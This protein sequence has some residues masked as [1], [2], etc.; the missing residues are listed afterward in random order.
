[1][2]DI[3]ILEQNLNYTFRD[4]SL[5]RNALVHPSYLNE[6]NMERIY[7]NQRL[8]FFG[9]SVLSLA[10][11]EY[12]FT[13]LKNF[14]EGRLTELRAKVVCEESLAKMAQRLDVGS[15]LALGKGEIKSGG[16]KRPSTLSD[17]M[18]AIIAAV[19]LD[20]G[21]ENAKKLVLSNLAEDIDRFSDSGDYMTNYKSDLQELVQSKGMSLE[22]TVIREWGPEHAKNFEV[23]AIVD[24]KELAVGVGS[25]KKKAEQEA[26]G[27]AYKKL[28]SK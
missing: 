1:M 17:A 18:E 4:I 15:Y 6:R 11:S 8:E 20:G 2:S 28:I 21:F 22:Y 19:Y 5:L 14:P 16:H 9:D 27:G 10:V 24:G 23:C 13:N 26:A 25:S 3:K 12:I 7:S